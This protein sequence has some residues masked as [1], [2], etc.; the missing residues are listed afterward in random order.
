MHNRGEVNA[1][2]WEKYFLCSILAEIRYT[3]RLAYMD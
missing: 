1:V 3:F 2:S